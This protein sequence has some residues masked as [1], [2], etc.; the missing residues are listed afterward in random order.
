[1][2]LAKQRLTILPSEGHDRSFISKISTIRD[3]Y[4]RGTTFKAIEYFD[5]SL[6]AGEQANISVNWIFG[7]QG[8]FI[9]IGD[10]VTRS[11]FKSQHSQANFMQLCI[12]LECTW[13]LYSNLLQHKFMDCFNKITNWIEKHREMFTKPCK[14]CGYHLSFKSGQ[15]LLPLQLTTGNQLVHLDCQTESVHC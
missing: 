10:H 13:D 9:V 4:A 14:I 2:N 1:M 15:P 3:Y 12:L 8:T 6:S 11:S 7:L 5:Y